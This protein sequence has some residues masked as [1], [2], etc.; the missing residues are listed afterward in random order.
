MSVDEE[1]D[2]TGK[3]ST[4]TNIYI[5]VHCQPKRATEV[6]CYSAASARIHDVKLRSRRKKRIEKEIVRK[7]DSIRKR[8]R[9]SQIGR[10]KEK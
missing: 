7:T 1:D 2:G 8:E 9:Q 10:R 6:H 5:Y 3:K 4:H